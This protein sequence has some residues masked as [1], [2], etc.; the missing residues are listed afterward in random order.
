MDMPTLQILNKQILAQKF[1]YI[2]KD[3]F[4]EKWRLGGI[5]F[6]ANSKYGVC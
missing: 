3:S 1:I 4:G 5:S 2:K 6:R